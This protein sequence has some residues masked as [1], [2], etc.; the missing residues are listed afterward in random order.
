MK[1]WLGAHLA[2]A[3]GLPVPPFQIAF[4]DNRLVDSYIWQFVDGRPLLLLTL[5][6]AS[7][8]RLTAKR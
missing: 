2:Q 8:W 1:E 5:H 7:Y 4:L 3:F 6:N